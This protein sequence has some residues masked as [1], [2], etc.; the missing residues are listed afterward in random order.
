MSHFRL[1][2]ARKSSSAIQEKYRFSIGTLSSS[3][4]WYNSHYGGELED[5]V[6]CCDESQQFC[7]ASQIANWRTCEN[8]RHM[9]ILSQ[10][11]STAFLP[12]TATH[13]W[14]RRCG[15][16]DRGRMI[17]V[18]HD[19]SAYKMS[20][21]QSGQLDEWLVLNHYLYPVRR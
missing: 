7:H 14:N 1:L 5:L 17:F 4:L 16:L 13:G 20:D 18:T 21:R 10:Y 2:E 9:T 11:S 6:A 19:V 12:P 8:S 3:M 15:S